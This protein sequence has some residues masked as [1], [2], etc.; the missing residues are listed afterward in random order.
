MK[1]VIIFVIVITVFFVYGIVSSR[2]VKTNH[3]NTS[4]GLK[5]GHITDTHFDNRY[6]V[7]QYQTVTDSINNEEVDVLF[8][9]GDLF[10]VYDLSDTLRSD[11]ISFLS[12]L[13][14][15]HKYAVLGNHDYFGEEGFND[16]V[17]DILESSGFTVLVNETELLD[18]DGVT[19]QIV[20]LD[21]WMLGDNNYLPVLESIEDDYETIVLSHEPDTFDIVLD[22][23][24]DAMFSGH[25][26]GG[27]IRVPLI[28]DLYNVD[29]A[30]K[31][32]EQYYEVDGKHLYISFGLG[33]SVVNF[34]L[35]NPRQLEIYE[36][37]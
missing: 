30:K 15:D 12:G 32:N 36:N 10:Q 28:G 13:N 1:F 9:T 11:I 5:I 34:R 18:V 24:I 6:T 22:Y 20:G 3:R 8:F 19:Y 14:C 35:Y 2:I 29:G 7:R 17:I 31:Y 33:E 23:N 37:S 16:E 27:Q 25:S 21:D 4:L 26:H